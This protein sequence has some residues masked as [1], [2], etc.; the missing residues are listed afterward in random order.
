VA[1]VNHLIKVNPVREL[2][3]DLQHQVFQ[4]QL[5]Q[6]AFLQLEVSLVYRAEALL[7]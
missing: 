5:E 4:G 7:A 6:L 3:E 2:T 1:Q